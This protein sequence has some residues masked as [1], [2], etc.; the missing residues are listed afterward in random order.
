LIALGAPEQA[1]AVG[2]RGVRSCQELDIGVAAHE[3]GRALA[4]AEA[5]LG[6]GKRAA[7][8]LEAIIAEQLEL[9]V[10]G[11]NLG[12]SYEARARIAVW[13]GEEPTVDRYAH[14]TARE[15]RRGRGSPLGARYERLMDEA[16]RIGSDALPR[17]SEYDW[18]TSSAS[19]LG[20]GASVSDVVSSALSGMETRVQRAERALTVMCKEWDA[21]A[22]HLYLFDESRHGE[23][24][25][26]HIASLGAAT[27]PEGLLDFL[28]QDF[29]RGVDTMYTMTVAFTSLDTSGPVS[30]TVFKDAKG[31]AYEP[32]PLFCVVDGE[33]RHAGIAV[34][35]QPKR[36]PSAQTG[37]ITAAIGAHL[38]RVGDTRGVPV[39][40]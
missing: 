25:L 6:D 3:I 18:S 40:A 8:R 30:A 11:L 19:G 14:L 16:R 39:G 38:I 10:S 37:L 5:K 32:A 2:E 24:E 35:V 21:D 1:R 9:G 20:R 28:N 33:A 36:P 29:G 13:A 12:A 22:G 34:L 4:L 23:L 26:T 15:Y 7:E 31:S 27:P 17:L